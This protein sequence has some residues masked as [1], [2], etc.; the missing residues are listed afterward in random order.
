MFNEVFNEDARGPLLIKVV[1]PNVE[2]LTSESE[3]I[4]FPQRIERGGRACYQ[5]ESKIAESSADGFVRRIIRSGHYS[6]LEHC[7]VTVSFIGSRTMSHQLVRHRIAAFSM[8]SQRYCNY[9]KMG[10]ALGVV[11]PPA[12]GHLGD[13]HVLWVGGDG[14]LHVSHDVANG[15]VATICSDSD[16]WSWAVSCLTSYAMYKRLLS[17]GVRPED[18]REVL[19]NATKT[20]I[21]TT[22]NLRQWRH[23]FRMRC[24]KKSQWQI[25][26]MALVVLEKLNNLCPSVFE[27]LA[28]EFLVD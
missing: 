1:H 25:R 12:I 11:L 9:G 18:A 20:E 26:G 17:S 2:V 13:G 21:V 5:S 22:F 24:D 6:V 3:I 23:F 19:P 8:E 15:G 27:D 10:G 14:V 7:S 16:L 4:S 28:D